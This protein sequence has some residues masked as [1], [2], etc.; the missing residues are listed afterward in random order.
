MLQS[1]I[2]SQKNKNQCFT[3][4]QGTRA[5]STKK[6]FSRTYLVT[7]THKKEWR[8]SCMGFDNA[9]NDALTVALPAD[10]NLPSL[11]LRDFKV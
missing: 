8:R 5:L 10:S 7:H 4:R 2:M 9:H 6:R 3:M 1:Q 11:L